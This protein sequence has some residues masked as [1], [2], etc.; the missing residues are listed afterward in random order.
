MTDIQKL[1]E[2]RLSNFNSMKDLNDTVLAE[3]RDYTSEETEKLSRMDAEYNSLTLK[4]ENLE[5]QNDRAASL[6][7][8]INE[9]AF[10]ARTGDI[11]ESK[12]DIEEKYRDAFPKLLVRGINGLDLEDKKLINEYRTTM[13]IST[14]ADGG[15]T[16]PVSYQATVIKKLYDTNVMRRLAKVIRTDSTTN[17]PLEGSKASFSWTSENA[18]YTETNPTFAQMTLSAYKNAGIIK[19]SEELLSDSFID[20]EAYLTDQI[21]MGA[22]DNEEAAF[23][24]GDGSAKPTGVVTGSSLGHTTAAAGVVTTD[25]ILDLIYSVGASYANKGSLLMNRSTELSVRKLK[26][27]NGQY[28]WQPSIQA[29][30][31]NTFDG[32]PI[33][34]S[35]YVPE[36]SAGNKFMLFGDFSYFLIADRGNMYIQRLNELF[37]A[38]GQVGWRAY[39][40]VDSK[41]THS[42]A[43]KHLIS[44]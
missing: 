3:K 19:A 38:N 34:N 42:E 12:V 40:R 6:K 43:I 26:D 29:G 22:G 37:A 18:A 28:L 21:V 23:V 25:E 36:L 44:A 31:P 7:Q 1:Y 9:V 16:V 33:S 14:P 10:D 24:A 27:S 20:L 35:Q 17:I 39:M 15:Y 13:N 8:T 30:L 2:E 11:N 5:K 4:I 41:I 32:K